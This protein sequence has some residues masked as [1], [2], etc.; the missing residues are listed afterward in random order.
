MKD[1]KKLSAKETALRLLEIKNPIVYLHRR[2][3]GDAVG[4]GS[5]L[6]EI[7]RQ[8]GAECSILSADP[9]P[10]RLRFITEFTKVSI[11]DNAEGKTAVA[12][13][14]ASPD[15]LGSLKD[16]APW[17]SL[18][19]DHH[20]I[21]EPFAD[22]Y[23]VDDASSAAEALFDVAL[24]LADMGK[25]QINKPLAYAL[26]CAISSDTG[27]FSYSNATAKTH[28]YAANLIELGI[29]TADINRRLFDSKSMEQIKAE[30]Y[31]ASVMKSKA[32]GRIAF[33][34]LT[35]DELKSLNLKSEHF[36]TSIDVIRSLSG[37]DIAFFLRETEHNVFKASLRSV[38]INVANVAAK[39]GGGGH[40]RASGCSLTAGSIEEAK[41]SLLNE[42]IKELV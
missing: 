10:E 12:I 32:D 25:I 36:E 19:I 1:Y 35:L 8:L 17:P 20:K 7:L 18:M 6:C 21:G 22:G 39:F 37:V 14:V 34:T 5:A 4:S 23:I 9:I 11:A 3:D 41:E 26:F 16:S 15:Q 31:I 2:P 42:L 29:D 33:A 28:R 13:D 24:M 27:C 38:G 30:G 40:I